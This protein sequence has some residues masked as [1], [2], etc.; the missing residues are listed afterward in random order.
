M[1]AWCR[2]V[3]DWC[4]NVADWARNVAD[5]CSGAETSSRFISPSRGA[6]RHSSAFRSSVGQAVAQN[7]SIKSRSFSV[8][9][10]LV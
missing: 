10:L 1:G 4:R 5:W 6:S 3:A 9:A 2:N 7:S 8:L